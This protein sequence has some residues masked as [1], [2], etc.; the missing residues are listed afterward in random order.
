LFGEDGSEGQC[1][2]TGISKNP[3][4]RHEKSK[5]KTG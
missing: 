5:K 3:E 4:K 2:G 1:K